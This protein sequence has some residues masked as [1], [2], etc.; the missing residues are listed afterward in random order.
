MSRIPMCCTDV[1]CMIVGC[2]RQAMHKVG[3]ENIFIERLEKEEH[4]NF[5]M[6]HNLTT[7][8]CEEHFN[9]LMNKET[10]YGD[11]SKLSCPDCGWPNNGHG[12]EHQI[13]GVNTDIK[14]NK[15][16]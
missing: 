10:F 4:D 11:I 2:I 14:G 16:I 1:K 13:K 15:I 12:G 3:E 5:N 7:Y 9:V 6:R 8:L